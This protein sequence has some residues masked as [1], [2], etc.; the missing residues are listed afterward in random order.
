M[1]VELQKKVIKCRGIKLIVPGTINQ[2]DIDALVISVAAAF[3][4]DPE[5]IY[6]TC[7]EVPYPDT[8]KVVWFCMYRI[9]GMTRPE[10]ATMFK[11]DKGSIRD[12]YVRFLEL[13]EINDPIINK[14]FDA[15]LNELSMYLY[16]RA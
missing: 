1:I 15:V 6:G 12:A 4:V 16:E 11:R 2:E 8:R 13:L 3:Y 9:Y 5:K 10:I 7:Q 14:K